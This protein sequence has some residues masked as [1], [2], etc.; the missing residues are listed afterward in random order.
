[1]VQTS[2]SWEN[3]NLRCMETKILI[4]ISINYNPYFTQGTWLGKRN[5]EILMI[6]NETT[7]LENLE[8]PQA[9]PMTKELSDIYS[10]FTSQLLE[11]SNEN[12]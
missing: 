12:I 3:G 7:S 10:L 2:T 1:M 8:I 5:V 4:N 6:K 9:I 11:K